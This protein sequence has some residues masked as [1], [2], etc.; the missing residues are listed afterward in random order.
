MISVIV[1]LGNP[2]DEYKK[3]RHKVGFLLLDA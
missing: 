1:G 3:T 2:G